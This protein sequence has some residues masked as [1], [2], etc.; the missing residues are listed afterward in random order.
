VIY[1]S[2]LRAYLEVNNG[3]L[4]SLQASDEYAPII[5][6]LLKNREEA[7]EL[8]TLPYS[9]FG[10]SIAVCCVDYTHQL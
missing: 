7:A 5:H 3:T 9:K 6:H 10:G 1:K 4:L 2:S 8:F